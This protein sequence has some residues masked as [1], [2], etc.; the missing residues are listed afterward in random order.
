MMIGGAGSQSSENTPEITPQIHMDSTKIKKLWAEVDSLHASN[1]TKSMDAKVDE[2]IPLLDIKTDPFSWVKAHIYKAKSI[3]RLNEEGVFLSMEYLEA[4]KAESSGVAISLMHAVLANVYSEYLNQN[5]FIL[6][7]RKDVDREEYGDVRQWTASEFMNTATQYYLASIKNESL[8]Q[9]DL[10]QA[11]VMIRKGKNSEK[12][13]SNL[14]ELLLVEALNHFSEPANLLNVHLN[15]FKLNDPA[16]FEHYREYANME[17]G[18]KDSMHT[19]FQALVLFQKA[20]QIFSSNTE[21]LVHFEMK[22]L[23]FLKEH[24]SIPGKDSLYKERI[25]K[26]LSEFEDQPS[27]LEVAYR[28]ASIYREEGQ[29]YNPLNEDTYDCRYKLVKAD[30]LLIEA[31]AQFPEAYGVE[32]C[33][34]L[35]EDLN[36]EVW[37]L[38][39]SERVLS[40]RP[41][42]SSL[43]FKNM[44]RIEIYTY[45]ITE[46]EKRSLQ[47]LNLKDRKAFFENK[48][49]YRKQSVDLP[50]TK[51]LQTHKVDVIIEGMKKGLYAIIGPGGGEEEQWYRD[52]RYL[53]VTDIQLV[54]RTESSSKMGI[55]VLSAKDG[56]PVEGATVESYENVYNNRELTEKILQKAI[57]DENGKV[58]LNY[59]NSIQVKGMYDSSI[60]HS[61]SIYQYEEFR[62]RNKRVLLLTDRSIYRPGQIVYFKGIAY[63]DSDSQIPSI[64]K[65]QSVTIKL[66]DT[67]YK[68]VSQLKLRS[69]D[70]GSFNGQFVLPTS[71]LTGQ[72]SIQIEQ[73]SGDR[74]FQVEEYKRPKFEVV[75]EQPKEAL[76]LGQDVTV[77]GKAL[78]FAGTPVRRAQADYVVQ[79]RTY[80][81]MM[82]WRYRYFPMRSETVDVA[83]GSIETDENGAFNIDFRAM[84]EEISNKTNPFYSF[85]VTV[86]ITDN[87][88]ETRSGDLTVTLGTIPYVL[89]M[90]IPDKVLASE[91]K[92]IGFDITNAQGQSQEKEAIIKVEALKSPEALLLDDGH[93]PADIFL[94]TESQFKSK[95]PNT[96]YNQEHEFENWKTLRNVFEQKIQ[97]KDANQVIFDASSWASGV[98]KI[99]LQT[100]NGNETLKKV[101]YLKV[102]NPEVKQ[103]NG[104]NS[105]LESVI[106]KSKLEPGQKANYVLSS[107]LDKVCV[108]L[109]IEKGGKLTREGWKHVKGNFSFELDATE[110]DRGGFFIHQA[111]GG[112][113]QVSIQNQRIV[114]PWSNKS[115]E[116]DWITERKIIEPGS[117]ET[118][119]FKLKHPKH[120]EVEVAAALYDASLD[121]LTPHHWGRI[122]FPNNRSSRYY[123]DPA[124]LG[125]NRL[126][127]YP[128]TQRY[129]MWQIRQ[130]P[131]IEMY[132]LTQNMY[133][134]IAYRG[135]R[136]EMY[137]KD[138]TP[139]SVQLEEVAMSASNDASFAG[140]DAVQPSTVS[141]TDMA[142]AVPII[143]ENLN[144][145]VFFYPEIKT[146]NE[147]EFEISF[148]M[149]EALTKWRL[150]LH[151]H[152]SDLASGY[153]EYFIETQKDLMVFPNVP[154]FLRQRDSIDL[155]MLVENLSDGDLEASG[156]LEITDAITGESL[157]QWIID[158]NVKSFSLKTNDATPISWKVAVPAKYTG[159][160]KLRYS[161]MGG[162]Q[163]DAEE[164]T[165]LVLTNMKLITESVGLWV[166]G[167]KTKTFE[168]D[169]IKDKFGKDSRTHLDFMLEFTENP[170]W[171]AVLALPYMSE[172]GFPN[173]DAIITRYY[174]NSLAADIVQKVPRLQAIFNQWKSADAL[175]SELEKNPELKAAVLAETPWVRQAEREEDQRNRIAMLFEM[176][177]LNNQLQQNIKDLKDLQKSS[178]GFAWYS[179]GREN[180]YTTQNIVEHFGHLDHLGVKDVREDQTIRQMLLS[181]LGYMDRELI[182]YYEKQQERIKKGDLKSDQNHLSPI[183]VHYLYTSS[184]FPEIPQSAQL[185]K[186]ISFYLD[187]VE[188]YWSTLGIYQ[189]GLAALSLNRNMRV[190]TAKNILKTLSENMIRSEELGFYW[191]YNNSYYWYQV[192]IQTHALMI[193][194]FDEI[195]DEPDVIDGMKRWLLKNKQTNSWPTQKSTVK[196]IYALLSTGGDWLQSENNVDIQISGRPLQIPADEKLAGSG[197]FKTR[198]NLNQ[199]NPQNPTIVLKNPG[200]VPAWG[201]FYW[202]YFQDIDK[203]TSFS[204]Y[205]MK[206]NKTLYRLVRDG[207]GQRSELITTDQPLQVGDI[208]NVRIELSLDRP[209]EFVHLKDMRASGLEPMEVLSGYQW[210][211]GLG[212]YRAIGDTGV[213]FFFDY[214]PAGSYVFEYQVRVF[215]AGNFA[216]GMA[217]IQSFYAPEFSAHSFGQRVVV[218]PAQ[219]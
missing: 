203:V 177:T 86:S 113:N 8:K 181:A 60:V 79:R 81:P 83:V 146:N 152:D 164:H 105:I 126:S 61:N 89:S 178:G 58:I 1:L 217:E 162:K 187:Q 156:T 64:I 18:T 197:Y 23:D 193:E 171:Y 101:A 116:I 115:F 189:Q 199:L 172:S 139:P 182:R 44:S 121:A 180:W 35:K 30:S 188:K 131:M 82:P 7:D 96:P 20:I 77:S 112:H 212:Y 135:V 205:P 125:Q 129:G 45:E 200:K 218:I 140:D 13:V 65:N 53:N 106:S 147:G 71:A 174:S 91:F 59:K 21:A 216:N 22:R 191:K 114:V 195:I 32:A 136:S 28:A 9:Y 138:G 29:E 208:I 127:F 94:Y 130:L 207:D 43:S 54:S 68:E 25:F 150:M 2:L 175:V 46:E 192:P 80:F 107:Q 100:M 206:L 111:F 173:A 27:Y 160:I 186:I 10:N 102:I 14:Y 39:F 19:H 161:A 93:G 88:G 11:S 67:N 33:K 24:G 108:L 143:R 124:S 168:L 166:N 215:H 63:E 163:T 104:F 37:S 12:I 120:S 219:K 137:A 55:W 196:A 165:I 70:Y 16:Y 145:T 159:M 154:R 179:G 4:R 183:V 99:T 149:N 85:T 49:M 176:N 213:D 47:R 214:I 153:S 141:E 84:G 26:Y 148:Q 119:R 78:M 167:G 103:H 34:A 169:Y 211:K 51:D 72:F 57:T 97:A 90:D 42:V 6:A 157:S 170:A 122:T 48:E 118:W 38:T 95:L 56:A 66:M 133:G 69:S 31:I 123:S 184:F 73:L 204:D 201:G 210:N 194:A 52:I 62:Q 36:Q 155:T 3:Q 134:Q 92:K 185:Q 87:A 132:G 50:D 190:V 151:G 109:A 41:F 128:R 5:L 76:T 110:A 198:I 202:Q 17:L 74:Y 117:Q 209:M 75:L 98:Y 158:D 142:D 15:S 40:N 144:E